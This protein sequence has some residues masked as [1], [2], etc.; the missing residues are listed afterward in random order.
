MS[1]NRDCTVINLESV[2]SVSTLNPPLKIP[3]TIY[4]NENWWFSSLSKTYLELHSTQ[5]L[6]KLGMGYILLQTEGRVLNESRNF[7]QAT[8]STEFVALLLP[9][10]LFQKTFYDTKVFLIKSCCGL[11]LWNIIW[12]LGRFGTISELTL[13][14]KVTSKST[15]KNIYWN[16]L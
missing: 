5:W 16:Y 4:N 10:I 1:L 9:L 6:L 13:L 15:G 8:L 11:Y 2:G 12:D 7:L 3:E 14:Y